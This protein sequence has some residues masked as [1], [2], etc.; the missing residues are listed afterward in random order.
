MCPEILY[1]PV[2]YILP[3][4]SHPTREEAVGEQ[5]SAFVPPESLTPGTVFGNNGWVNEWT[6]LSPALNHRMK[7]TALV[8]AFGQGMVCELLSCIQ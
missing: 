1:T 4:H 7:T 2:P 3:S 5:R 8:W 6:K